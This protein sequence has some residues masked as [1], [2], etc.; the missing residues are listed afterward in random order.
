M[1]PFPILTIVAM[2]LLC[3]SAVAQ[4]LQA[5]ETCSTSV[6]APQYRAGVDAY[7]RKV[8]PADIDPAPPF[9]VRIGAIERDAGAAQ[10]PNSRVI[11]QFRGLDTLTAPD[12]C[13]QLPPVPTQSGQGAAE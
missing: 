2:V 5:A 9:D 13:A 1:A 10:V 3:G 7:G 8:A 12:A 4:T 6:T 11:M